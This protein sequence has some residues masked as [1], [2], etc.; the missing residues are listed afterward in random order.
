M[1]RRAIVSRS[2]ASLRKRTANSWGLQVRQHGVQ[3]AA[4]RQMALDRAVPP[5]HI[6]AAL[7]WT[8]LPIDARLRP[9]T[10][11]TETNRIP[12]LPGAIRPVGA[13]TGHPAK[14]VTLG[15]P[16]ARP[17]LAGTFLAVAVL[18]LFAG[19]AMNVAFLVFA[20]FAAFGAVV[21]C[22]PPPRIDDDG[23]GLTSAMVDQDDLVLFTRDSP[24][25]R[26]MQ[27]GTAEYR[28][29]WNV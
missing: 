27:P 7:R 1:T 17:G 11:R 23:I 2:N 6:N 22:F 8:R 12:R 5:S 16:V 20:G 14:R 25:E 26:S 4:S 19:I 3:D 10:A 18:F 28:S 21:S 13:V 15:L 9:M 24:E 29:R